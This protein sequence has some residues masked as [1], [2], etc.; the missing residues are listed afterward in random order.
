MASGVASQFGVAT[1]LLGELQQYPV[2]LWTTME[3]DQINKNKQDE[4]CQNNIK[5]V[6]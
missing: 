1:V 3:Y 5:P 6:P 2:A 4:A